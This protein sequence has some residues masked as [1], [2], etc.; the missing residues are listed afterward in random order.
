MEGLMENPPCNK[1]LRRSKVDNLPIAFV[2]PPSLGVAE[3]RWILSVP[4]VC[5][6]Q[7]GTLVAFVHLSKMTNIQIQ[8]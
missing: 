2:Y 8:C 3:V 5:E 1:A 4:H 7:V 6:N